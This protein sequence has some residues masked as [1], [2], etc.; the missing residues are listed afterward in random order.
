VNINIAV[1]QEILLTLR[2]QEDDFAL[3]MKRWTT[4]KLYANKKLTIGQ[5]A[6]FAEMNEEDFIKYLGLNKI[7]IFT[8]NDFEELKEDIKNA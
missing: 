3:N 7:S 2:E 8:F 1:P 6:E 5:C 4:L